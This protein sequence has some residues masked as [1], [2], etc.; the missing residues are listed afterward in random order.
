LS[1]VRKGNVRGH[2]ATSTVTGRARIGS[3]TASPDHPRPPTTQV[4]CI[5]PRR[6]GVR[7]PLAPSERDPCLCGGFVVPGA[8]PE[9]P[10]IALHFRH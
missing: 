4:D 8:A 5:A 1:G 10:V 7:V 9:S 6:S 2:R 3:R